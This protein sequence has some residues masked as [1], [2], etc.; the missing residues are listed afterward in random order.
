M[1]DVTLASGIPSITARC[2]GII[3]PIARGI[4][5]LYDSRPGPDAPAAS[6]RFLMTAL[7]QGS[8]VACAMFLTGQASNVLAVGLAAQFAN[9]TITWSSW[10]LAGL[11]P[12]IVSC[13]IV[14][15]VVYRMV[16]PEITHT[17]GAAEY[18]RDELTRMGP[19][20]RRE[21]DRACGVRRR[22]RALDD[23]ALARARRHARGASSASACCSSPTC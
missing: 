18:A 5:E 22:L 17:P 10:F 1:S 2:G 13:V 8:A 11:V 3:L 20:N 15:L 14:P 21:R 23:L 9:V 19:L 12:G 6:A 16:P 7:Y 4:A